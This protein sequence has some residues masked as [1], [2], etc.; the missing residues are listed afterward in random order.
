MYVKITASSL[1]IQEAAS[2]WRGITNI[3]S[4]STPFRGNLTHAP[5]YWRN[6]KIRIKDNEID[7][8]L[9]TLKCTICIMCTETSLDPLTIFLPEW[10][11]PLKQHILKIEVA[12]ILVAIKIIWN[13]LFYLVKYSDHKPLSNSNRS[14][15]FKLRG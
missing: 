12:V 15:D 10:E 4:A 9:I 2:W 13:T 5:S 3:W 8:E 6:W 7:T 14:F 11:Y 1:F